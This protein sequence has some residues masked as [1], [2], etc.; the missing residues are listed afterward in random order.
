MIEELGEYLNIEG[1]NIGVD[2]IFQSDKL[3]LN[4]EPNPSVQE[5][6]NQLLSSPEEKAREEALKK[7]LNS[8]ALNLITNCVTA[9]EIYYAD[10]QRY[11]ASVEDLVK[12]GISYDQ[13]QVA[14]LIGTHS[15]NK[16]YYM[17]TF[18]KNGSDVYSVF[19]T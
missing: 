12:C 16:K 7:S 2:L 3:T 10:N 4:G 14:L 18:A 11:T 9:Q 15:E 6:F 13:N 8:S 17:V 19:W 1:E 5:M